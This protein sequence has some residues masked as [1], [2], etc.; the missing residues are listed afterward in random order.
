MTFTFLQKLVHAATFIK[1]KIQNIIHTKNQ[2]LFFIKII[3]K[4][5]GN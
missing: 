3:H 5:V 4:T 2:K 1:I